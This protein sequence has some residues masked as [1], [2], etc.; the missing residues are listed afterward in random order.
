MTIDPYYQRHSV[1]D[2]SSFDEYKV[3]VDIQGDSS[4][5]YVASTYCQTT[6]FMSVSATL[7]MNICLLL[8]YCC[9]SNETRVSDNRTQTSGRRHEHLL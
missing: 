6:V 8:M 5:R 2:D 1:G 7:N 3:Y 4:G 9:E